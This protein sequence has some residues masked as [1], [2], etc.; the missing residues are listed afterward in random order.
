MTK[1]TW[2]YT[3]QTLSDRAAIKDETD[4]VIALVSF[5]LDNDE[6]NQIAA[7]IAAAPQLLAV[8]QMALAAACCELT[9]EQLTELWQAAAEAYRAATECEV[10][11]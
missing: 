7:L 3:P 2:T 8:A 9:P 4:C 6:A 5:R 1:P 11:E 10:S